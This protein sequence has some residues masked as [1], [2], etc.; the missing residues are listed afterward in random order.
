MPK[1]GSPGFKLGWIHGC[2]SGLGSQFGGAFF[3]S[4]YSWKRDPDIASV[5]PNITRIRARYK[6]ELKDVNWDNP[7]EVKKNLSDYNS[8]TVLF[9]AHYTP[10]IWNHLFPVKIVLV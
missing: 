5:D 9:L 8:V 7:A 6:K 4:F 10:P 2:E 1:N 3:M